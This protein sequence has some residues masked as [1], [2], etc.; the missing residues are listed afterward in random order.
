MG[1]IY[2]FFERETADAEAFVKEVKRRF[3]LDG[4]VFD[5]GEAAAEY[6]A[7]PFQL[8]S[9]PF[10]VIERPDYRPDDADSPEM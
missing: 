10:A 4:K 2:D 8:N 3:G 1:V 9:P 5:D 6:A 7:F